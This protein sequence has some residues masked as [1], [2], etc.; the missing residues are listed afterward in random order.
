MLAA[1]SCE[2]ELYDPLESPFRDGGFGDG[3]APLDSD[4]PDG[5]TDG[6]TDEADAT[7]S[8]LAVCGYPEARYGF[9]EGY[10]LEPF[11]L[12]SCDGRGTTLPELWCGRAVTIVHVNIL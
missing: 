6:D 3:S 7:G 12:W 9:F 4:Q 11:A 5:E 1:T 2:R 10:N 8:H